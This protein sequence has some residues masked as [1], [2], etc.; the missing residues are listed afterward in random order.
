[1]HQIS[2]QRLNY[3]KRLFDN[4]HLDVLQKLSCEKVWGGDCKAIIIIV[5]IS[6]YYKYN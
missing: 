2:S 5:I 1:M 6:L 3:K 4:R